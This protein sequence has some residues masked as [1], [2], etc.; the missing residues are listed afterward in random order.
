MKISPLVI[1]VLLSFLLVS[2]GCEQESIH[3]YEAPIA[4]PLISASPGMPDSGLPPVPTEMLGAILP[5]GET[6]WFFKLTAPPATVEKVREEFGKFVAS[7]R[8]EGGKPSWEIPAHWIEEPGRQ[9]R[10]TTYRIGENGPEV[11]ISTLPSGSDATEFGLANVNRWRGQ[12]GLANL[13]EEQ[14]LAEEISDG[15]GE[16]VSITTPAGK[17]ILI[18]FVGEMSPAGGAP[19]A[20]MGGAS[21]S[22]PAPR[23]SPSADAPKTTP[24]EHWKPGQLNSFR[25]A[26][27]EVTE[28]DQK[29]EITISVAGGD[30]L[31]NVNRWRGQV[32]LEPW[33]TVDL[34][35]E[36]KLI[37]GNGFDAAS[38]A[39]IGPVN[40]ILGAVI[41]R[42]GRTWFVKL[43]GPSELAKTEQP[44]FERFVETLE[45]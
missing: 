20:N 27:F 36:M 39:L 21:P 25:I 30:L 42:D 40:T 31:A 18:D 11:S 43:T 4:K 13:T 1:P 35:R 5:Q 16:L 37:E 26:A 12:L 2:A 8:I 33:S 45:F 28:G 14:Y 15:S 29:A 44:H 24:P 17:A 10:F 9:M 34:N 38:V 6:T 32:D 22:G 7:T 23:S 41:E 19:F 3:S